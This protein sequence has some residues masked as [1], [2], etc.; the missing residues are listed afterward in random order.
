MEVRMRIRAAVPLVLA[1]LPLGACASLQQTARRQADFYRAGNLTVLLCD[2]PSLDGCQAVPGI[3]VASG[4]AKLDQFELPAHVRG[5]SP[6]RALRSFQVICGRPTSVVLYEACNFQGRVAAYHCAPAP[7][8]VSGILEVNHL[9]SL[10][11]KVGAISFSDETQTTD[12]MHTAIPL[13]TGPGLISAAVTAAFAGGGMAATPPAGSCPLIPQCC[14]TGG[15]A[16]GAGG[17]GAAGIT[18]VARSTDVFWTDAV[19]VA[20]ELP[21]PDDENARLSRACLVR[22]DSNW[23]RTDLLAVVHRMRVTAGPNTYPVALSW[24]FEPTL[25]RGTP[26]FRVHKTHFRV[27]G[28]SFPGSVLDS[29]LGDLVGLSP[30]E[31]LED[32]IARAMASSGRSIAC[33]ILAAV[34]TAANATIAGGG[35][36]VL[37]GN[38]RANFTYDLPPGTSPPTVFCNGIR[39][40]VAGCDHYR[41][42]PPTLI[43]HK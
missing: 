9:G 28:T 22:G 38:T 16:G 12:T 19:N 6:T 4:T 1:T 10:A 40:P 36:A 21:P 26:V 14:P 27:Y 33:G 8:D 17:G 37:T 32:G 30:Q 23:E 2:K 43:L 5:D 31:R 25:A 20:V 34:N 35:A 7:G 39:T 11:G 24:Y 13:V 18:V 15:G 29:W 3:S 41:A 42:V